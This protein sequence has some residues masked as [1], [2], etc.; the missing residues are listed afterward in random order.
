MENDVLT[1]VPI[2]AD[3]RN[4]WIGWR[5]PTDR[6]DGLENGWRAQSAVRRTAQRG[7]SIGAHGC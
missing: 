7:S 6:S 1:D 4:C 2:D 3:V 5:A